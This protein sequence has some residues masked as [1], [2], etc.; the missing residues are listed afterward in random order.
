MGFWTLLIHLANF[1]APAAAVGGLLAVLAPW[2]A[3]NRP[4]AR[5]ILVQAAINAV[6]GGSVLVVGLV[7]FGNDGKM[8][9]YAA[10]VLA[11]GTAQ[12]LGMRR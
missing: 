4:G 1:L 2:F 11:I 5:K 12:V 10:L 7:V 8:A 6:A 9:T 3:S